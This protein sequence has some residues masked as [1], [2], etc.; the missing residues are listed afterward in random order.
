MVMPNY[1]SYIADSP[2]LTTTYY[3]TSAALAFIGGTLFELGSYLMVVEALNRGRENDFGP[4]LEELLWD[5]SSPSSSSK[6]KFLWWGKPL[7]H[8]LGYLAAVIQL[9][10]ATVFWISTIT[11]LPGVIPGYPTDSNVAITDVFFWTPQ[12]EYNIGA[13]FSQ[14]FPSL[15]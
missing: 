2:S 10:A 4:S 8:D 15:T 6:A 12:G 11:G 14:V 1:L 3:K 9:F 7:W 13:H 5:S